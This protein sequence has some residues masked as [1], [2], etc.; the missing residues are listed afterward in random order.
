MKT[1]AKFRKFGQNNCNSE[2]LM[3]QNLGAKGFRR[4]RKNKNSNI[5][6]KGLSH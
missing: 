2:F 3:T 1:I 4:N 5:T 6:K